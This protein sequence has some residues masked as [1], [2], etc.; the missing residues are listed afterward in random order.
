MSMM[1]GWMTATTDTSSTHYAEPTS[2]RTAAK[3]IH[4]ITVSTADRYC[5][6]LHSVYAHGSVGRQ[7]AVV[8]SPFKLT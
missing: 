4:V 6:A 8:R 2:C 1:E 7:Q 5:A 3:G